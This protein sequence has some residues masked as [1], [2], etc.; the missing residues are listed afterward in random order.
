VPN[1]VT[2]IPV[3]P[4]KSEGWD[5]ADEAEFWFSVLLAHGLQAVDPRTHMDVVYVAH[6]AL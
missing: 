3:T 4:L 2:P 5:I 6:A 1:P